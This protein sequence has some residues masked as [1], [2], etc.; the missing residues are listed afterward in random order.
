MKT[1]DVPYS[2]ITE[3]KKSPKKLFEEAENKK[4][5]VY[6]FNR[7]RPAGVVLSVVDYERLVNKNEE[8]KD[9][10]FEMEQDYEVIKRLA[11]QAKNPEPLAT[12]AEV[13]GSVANENPEIDEKD[14]WE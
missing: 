12:D 14:G 4:T 1:M 8:L 5:G 13:R 2:N 10:V 11:K 9:K 3:L 7:D 6:V